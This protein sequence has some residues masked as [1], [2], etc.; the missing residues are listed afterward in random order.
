MMFGN[1]FSLVIVLKRYSLVFKSII[2]GAF[3]KIIRQ[4]EG[5]A[6]SCNTNYVK[7]LLE[8]VRSCLELPRNTFLLIEFFYKKIII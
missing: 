1:F 5:Y 7:I 3:Q 2:R 8:S 4:C 6:M